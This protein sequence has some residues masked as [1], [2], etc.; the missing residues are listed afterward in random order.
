M[1]RISTPVYIIHYS[2]LKDR[3]LYLDN[4]LDSNFKDFKFITDFDKEKLDIV[5]VN[6]RY[7]EDPQVF[8]EKIFELWKLDNLEYRKLSDAEISCFFK[9]I[10]ALREVAN[11]KSEFSLILEDDV[12]PVEKFAKGYNKM[13]NSLSNLNWDIV[14]IG[15]GIGKNFI[16]KKMGKKVL[17]SKPQKVEHPASN[18]ADSY[19][20]KKDVA[21][22]LLSNFTTF[23]LSYDWELAY[24]MYKLELNVYWAT[25]PLFKQ[26]SKTGD[27]A[28]ALR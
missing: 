8:K 23:H 24:Q 9:H 15:S 13:I 5:N 14:F 22:K 12:I 11:S 28:S 6:E 3:K 1:K 26:G 2:K 10:Q 25:R 19:I 21:K 16:Y 17:F 18:C 4:F 27:Y 20:V 7:I